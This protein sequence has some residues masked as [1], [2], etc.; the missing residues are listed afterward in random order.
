MTSYQGGTGCGIGY[1]GNM[2]CT[3]GHRLPG[4]SIEVDTWYNGGG[5]DPTT[6]DH[7]MFTFDGSNETL[8]A[9]LPEMEDTGWHKMTVVINAPNVYVAIDDAV[10]ET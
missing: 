6:L 4:W 3:G 7:L 5:V 8:W 10:Q 1:G 9:V 2:S